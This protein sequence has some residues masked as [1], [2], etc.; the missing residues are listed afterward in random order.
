M[1]GPQQH[2]KQPEFNSVNVYDVPHLL[3]HEFE[4]GIEIDD[5]SNDPLHG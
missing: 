1:P 4:E 5:V 2:T 3:N